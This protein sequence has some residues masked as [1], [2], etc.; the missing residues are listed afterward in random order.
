MAILKIKIEAR[1]AALKKNGQ[2]NEKLRW[3]AAIKLCL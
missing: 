3:G 1:I 2:K